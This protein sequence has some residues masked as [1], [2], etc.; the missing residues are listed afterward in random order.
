MQFQY[1]STLTFSETLAGWSFHSFNGK[2]NDNEWSDVTGADLDFGARIYDS[3]ICRWLS[4]DAKPKSHESV[5]IGFSNNPIWFVDNSGNDTLVFMRT[6]VGTTPNGGVTLYTLTASVIVNGIEEALPQ[7]YTLFFNND[8]SGENLGFTPGSTINDWPNKIYNI[9]DASWVQYTG[10]SK[11]SDRPEDVKRLIVAPGT[12]VNGDPTAST[13]EPGQSKGDLWGC[14]GICSYGDYSYDESFGFSVN[15]PGSGDPPNGD[16][17]GNIRNSMDA[18]S[19]FYNLYNN[20]K[21]DY[22]LNGTPAVI[23]QDPATKKD[24]GVKG[25]NMQKMPSL[26]P[27]LIE[28]S[29]KKEIILK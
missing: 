5:Y 27:A 7:R 24:L 15:N 26:K 25:T 4:T 14:N 20:V 12:D 22:N 10:Y 11:M 29:E 18:M 28:S 6:K 16:Y 9:T 2:E 13:I 8:Y 21:A 3:R 23:I 1:F 17:Y 19:D